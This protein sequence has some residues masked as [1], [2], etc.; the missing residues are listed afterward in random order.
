MPLLDRGY[1]CPQCAT[2]LITPYDGMDVLG[3]CTKCNK[4]WSEHYWDAELSPVYRQVFS[5]GWIAAG[6]A[7]S[8]FTVSCPYKLRS[9]R[10]VQFAK[11]WMR[12]YRAKV[13]YNINTGRLM[14]EI[15]KQAVN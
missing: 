13:R 2:E 12:G 3:H 15:D 14:A 7:T 9:G 6:F 11:A 4:T 10:S 8:D 1:Y 5:K